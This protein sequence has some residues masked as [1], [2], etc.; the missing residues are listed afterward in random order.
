MKIFVAIPCLNEERF[1]GDIVERARKYVDKVIVVDDGSTDRT[2]VVARD[3]GA[4]VIRHQ[5]S[6]GAGAATSTAFKAAK[7]QGADILVTIDGDGQH[8]PDEIPRLIQPISEGKADF[9]IGSRFMGIPSNMQ[10]YRRF[11]IDLITWLFNVCSK[12][13][14]TD[15]QSGFRAHSR[16]LL[17][18]VEIKESGFAF[19]IEVLEKSRKKG[20]AM[21]AV[22]I[23]CIYHSDGSSMNPVLH[24]LKVA[25]GVIKYRIRS[26]FNR[27]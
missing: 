22:P 6:L 15:S 26:R 4:E 5:A 7:E 19:S 25:W 2:S 13:G 20:L 23:S 8:N 11:G 16:K 14:I 21:V 18:T 24:G 27:L 12:T 10:R 9:V 1:I 17:E 3:A